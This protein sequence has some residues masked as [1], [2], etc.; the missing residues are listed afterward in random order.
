M[1]L[2]IAPMAHRAQRKNDAN[3][4]QF[5]H[6]KTKGTFQKPQTGMACGEGVNTSRRTG[7][8]SGRAEASVG[9]IPGVI[10]RVFAAMS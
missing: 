6:R 10:V 5:M 1:R 9:E 7:M 8:A 3:N 2:K 4:L